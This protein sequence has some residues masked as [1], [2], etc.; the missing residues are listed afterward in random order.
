MLSE[1]PLAEFNK[2]VAETAAAHFV[3]V[4]HMAPV[5]KQS[6]S[7]SI[8][9]VSNGAGVQGVPCRGMKPWL[10]LGRP[11]CAAASVPALHSIA[12]DAG[13]ARHTRCP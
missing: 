4:K 5:L 7:S 13:W 11:G 2:V 10:A 1:Q 3:F 9:F 6:A 8:L 12:G